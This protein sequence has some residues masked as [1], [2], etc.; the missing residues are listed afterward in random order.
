MRNLEQVK[1]MATKP[2]IVYVY[3]G[4]K[5]TEI[6]SDKLLPNDI[7][8]VVKQAEGKVCPCDVLLIEGKCV[9][10]E[11]LLTG[12]SIPQ[13][14]ES[15]QLQHDNG[16]SEDDEM[17]DIKKR[18]KRHVIFGGTRIMH[19]Q[20]TIDDNNST[21]SR[22]KSPNNGAVGVVLR[23]GFETAQ[24]KLIRTILY[25]TERVSAN[26]LEALLFILFLLVFAV[27]ASTYVLLHGLQDPSR[28]RYKLLLNC[29]LII[30]SCVP[31]ELPMELSL[32]V[33]TSLMFLVRFGV[34]CT[35]PFRIPFAGKVN[36]CCF[37]KTGTLTSDKMVM[38]GVVECDTKG[39]HKVIQGKNARR[40][41]KAVLAGC[42]SLIN[43]D[44]EV[45]GDP[46]EKAALDATDFTVL[47]TTPASA[48]AVVVPQNA[49]TAS[50]GI[51]MITILKR[52]AF[53]SELKRMSCI[54]KIRDDVIVVSKGA[55]EIMKSM[56]SSDS[57]P[58]NYDDMLEEYAI[59]GARV[60]TL[61]HRTIFNK[62]TFRKDSLARLT[63]EDVE[64]DLVFAGFALFESDIKMGT[65]E[66]IDH[67]LESSHKVIMITGDNA[68]TACHVAR[69]LRMVTKPV[70]VLTL[71]DSDGGDDSDTD[72]ADRLIW[73]A[74]QEQM[75][76]LG[77]GSQ[78][79]DQLLEQYDLCV[80]GDALEALLKCDTKWLER[81]AA[82][83]AVYARV[84]P[85]QKEHVL[86]LL[87]SQGNFTLM[88]GDGT[89]D[90]GA[91]KQAHVG[92]ALLDGKIDAEKWA[93]LDR[94][95]SFMQQIKEQ[96]ERQ[97][98]FAEERKRLMELAKSGDREAASKLKQ[99]TIRQFM[100]PT[101]ASEGEAPLVKLGDASIASPFSSKYSTIRST[102]KILQQGRCTLVTTL[103]MYKILALNCL[104]SAYSLSVLYLDGVKYGDTQMLT[105]GLLIALCFLFISRAKPLDRLSSER[106]QSTIFNPYMMLSIMGQFAIHLV[107]LILTVQAAKSIA[108][109]T[110][111]VDMESEYEPNLLNTAVFL[112]TSAQTVAT[113]SNNYRGRPFMESLFEHKPLLYCLSAL[114]GL[115]VVL[116]AG[117]MPELNHQMELVLIPNQHIPLFMG[118]MA[119]NLAG[120]FIYERLLL[121]LFK[122]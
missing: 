22:R 29:I 116:T 37:D 103:Q 83:I 97:R 65:A 117:I 40:E 47:D 24:G 96:Q 41:V 6:M 121:R 53:T 43:L 31:P 48:E 73:H 112:I 89:N 27:I 32:A 23:T 34:F 39:D 17:L 11:S 118:I 102:E 113:F 79:V 114:F 67:L 13:M 3:R 105:T 88:C 111:P 50:T 69:K 76:V 99:L 38:T 44:G 55:P 77:S 10:N 58:D 104:I 46:M 74:H 78:S 81:H 85:E 2:E 115:I 42:H 92:V 4:R 54:V 71:L 35:E 45:V 68:M 72:S 36:V 8:S 49:G 12:E 51:A 80:Q 110:G 19:H 28:S 93:S 84:A 82:D 86:S 87:K 122:Q 70:L 98:L 60:I 120:V 56:I 9:T 21:T 107:S 26:N 119:I 20:Q 57:L 18:H 66:A 75:S 7:V 95:V 25:T 101:A 59:S 15:L 108:P 63:R 90:V 94:P 91:L 5:W 30:T 100:G 52:F 1:Q 64:K 14:K 61:A 33:N 62:Q 109:R 106:P 16:E